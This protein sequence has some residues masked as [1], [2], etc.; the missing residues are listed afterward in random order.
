MAIKW[1]SRGLLALGLSLAAH[2]AA[3]QNYNVQV[4]GTPPTLTN[5]T[6][7][8]SIWESPNGG[9]LYVSLLDPTS[10][11][12]LGTSGNPL[13]TTASGGADTVN[14]GTQ[15][16]SA[17]GST[18]FFQQYLGGSAVSASNPVPVTAAAGASGTPTQ[19][20]V[21]CG[22]SSSTVLA[23]AS[24][25]TSESFHLAASAANPVWLNFAG[26]A[27][28]TAAPTFDLQPGQTIVYTA[29]GG[30]LPTSAVTCIATA[31][32]AVTEIYK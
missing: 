27:A 23:A 29:V 30:L 2:S 6:N 10:G 25:A 16:A 11:A 7:S 28:T 15:A 9:G 24:A 8:P 5:N 3:A 20:A 26:A 17:T 14:Q 13:V 22:T 19:T 21:T 32:T 4:R 31:S 12:F 1:R 18:W